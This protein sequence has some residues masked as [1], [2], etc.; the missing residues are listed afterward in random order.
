MTERDD[1]RR[2]ASR[3][4][5][6]RRPLG[7]SG[8][9][10]K[11]FLESKLTPLLV[12]TSLLL[13]A[14]ALMVT[15][16]EEEPQIQVPMIDVFVGLPGATA[17]EVS[18]RVVGPLEKVLYEIENVEHVYSTSQPSGGIIIARFLVG[19]DPDEAVLRVH[20]KV[21]EIRPELPENVIPPVVA[22]RSIDDVPVVAYTLSSDDAAPVELRRVAAELKRVL[23]SHPRVSEVALIGGGRRELGID[24]DR[25]AMAAYR[26]SPLQAHQALAGLDWRLP[27]GAF[28]SADVETVVD[29][30]ARLRT[31]SDVGNAVVGV[32]GGD[33]VYLRDIAEITDG[34]AEPES[35]VWILGGAA[36]EEVGLTPEVDRPAITVSV[37]KKP[38]TNAIDL[39]RDLDGLMASLEGGLIPGNVE[40]TKT[41]DYGFTADEKS[42]E[43]IK[44]LWI[45]TLAVVVLMAFAL[46]RREAVVVLVAV[47][48][49]LA[50]TL[51]SS[52]LFGYTLNRVT[53]FALIFA[54]GILVD[55]AI[56]VVENIHRH[57]QLGWTNPRHATVYATDEVGN[58]TILATFTV[59]AA[60]LPLAFVSGL[61]GPYMRPIPINASAA[62][63][64]SLLVA[65]VVS[66]WLTYRLFRRHAE[67]IAEGDHEPEDET[68][69]ETRLHRDYSRLMRPLLARPW[70][71]WAALG[72][73]ALLLLLSVSLF[74]FEAVV[75]KMLPYD[76]KSEVQVI[77]DTPEGTTMEST[78][79]LARRLAEDVRLLPEVTDVEV[80]VGTSAPYN[81]NGLVR[82]YFLRSGP[83]VADLQVN[84]RPKH[85]RE[86]PSHAFA[87][88]LRQ[89][90]Q[91][92]MEG[93]GAS[94]KVTEVPPGPPVLSTLV[95][96]VYG[97]DLEKRVELAGRV[98]EIFASTS[99]VVDVDWFVENPG[100]RVELTVDREKAVRLGVTPEAVARTLRVSLAGAPVGLLG[101]RNAREPVPMVLR[102]ERAHR[103]GIDELT[104][105]SVHGP[106]GRLIPLRELVTPRPV[107]RERFVY[108][109]NL[110]PVTYVIA[111][112][113]GAQESPV[114]AILEMQDRI[115]ALEDPLG[116]P[117]EVF[118]THPPEGPTDYAVKWDGEWEIT[119]KVFRDMGIAFA[120]VL[121]LIYVLVV[122]WFGSFVTPLIIMAPI[123]LTLV[124]ILPAH[125][126][127]GVFFT[128]TSMIG[129]IALAGII[130]RNSILLVDF[131][132]LELEA[133][134]SLEDAVVK[135]GVV[136][137]RPIA[138]T[139]A[140][141]VVGGSV[142][143]LD[144][145]FQGLAVALISGVVVSTALTLMVIPL[146]YYM[147]IRAVGV[148]AITGEESEGDETS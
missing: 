127:G 11:A 19:S 20:A 10:A 44:H 102:L 61:M 27:A 82:H 69:E 31:R 130:V 113:S 131:V 105:L 58:P 14:F 119:W 51:A 77:V 55:D 91:P 48:T 52:Y 103:S 54:I 68:V 133:G 142:I 93:T 116:L 49:T 35:Y 1:T 45:A 17:Q 86:R 88:A 13:G 109:K 128:A 38:G 94:V 62:M 107:E 26:V 60:L 146:L 16:R 124:G 41:R 46:G 65:F 78:G 9:I 129:F 72:G 8:R 71:R 117:L 147:Y 79:A 76:N 125:A 121:V 23:S 106:E 5:A 24:L 134:E 40:V 114:Y 136:R 123:P 140:A 96:E 53:L 64:F 111:E 36:A 81:F 137:F 37:A 135:A 59:V 118:A 99:G 12:L 6:R 32:Y 63:I 74:Y 70:R 21:A 80:Y 144:P 101:E 67:E 42:S 95:A 50:L 7:L 2:Q 115:E 100:P 141:L 18:R 84:L 104:G 97:P 73:V 83:V 29:V 22:P 143:L 4:K 25:E 145:I 112:V 3:L 75:V 85:H 139:A 30:D 15:P 120:V 66:P 138:L 34:P 28:D 90:I 148:Q 39:V 56:V 122:G 98:K 87:K 110:R 57:Y 92:L 108:H 132:N 126:L 33:P 89:R 43:L 47:P